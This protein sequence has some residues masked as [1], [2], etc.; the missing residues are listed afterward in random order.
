MTLVWLIPPP[1][2]CGVLQVPL[3]VGGHQTA[4]SLHFLVTVLLT[5]FVLVHV[6]MVILAG[7]RARMRA[8]IT[9]RAAPPTE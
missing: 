4:R 7:F 8:M 5:L 2:V 9:G 1:K 3:Q 6:V